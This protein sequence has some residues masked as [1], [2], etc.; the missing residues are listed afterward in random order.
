MQAGKQAGKQT[1]HGTRRHGTAR[2]GTTQKEEEDPTDPDP[3]TKEGPDLENAVELLV[4]VRI[5]QLQSFTTEHER[6]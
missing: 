5:P 6:G 2:H 3:R 1:S 4:A